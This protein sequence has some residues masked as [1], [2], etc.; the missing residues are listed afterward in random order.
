MDSSGAD[1]SADV[2]LTD[3]SFSDTHTADA[4]TALPGLGTISGACGV[5]DDEEWL[6]SAPFFFRNTLDFGDEA[7]AVEKLSPGG[8]EVIDD[9]NLG[10][11]SLISEAFSFEVLYRC[12]LATLLKTER[13][14][15]Y[16]DTGGKKT[17][18][19][20]SI[21]GR[22]IGV[23]VTR[24]YHYP[25]DAPYTEAEARILL[26]DKLPEILLSADNADPANAWERSI[27]HIL[28]YNAQ[29]ADAVQAVYERLDAATRD[30]TIVIVTVTDGQDAHLY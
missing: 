17:D 14:I 3:S 18:L 2:V 6:S 4:F 12:E 25:P 15:D 27:L 24:A 30:K 19:L 21:D 13:E 26:E 23:S 11:G 9:E 10:G 8:Q 22:Q 29:Y 16:L 28:A 7:Y 20:L 1:A 5:L